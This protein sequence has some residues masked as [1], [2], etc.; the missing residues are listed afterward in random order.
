MKNRIFSQL[1]HGAIVSMA[2]VV[3]IACERDPANAGLPYVDGDQIS[4]GAME[5]VPVVMYT[6]PFDSV[7]SNDPSSGIGLFGGYTD[8]VFGRHD[9]Q[10][11]AH[12]LPD[13]VPSFGSNPVCDSAYLYIPFT[14]TSSAWYGDTTV[15]MNIQVYSLTHF[16]DPDSSYYSHRQFAT[17]QLIGDTTMAPNPRRPQSFEVLSSNR[18]VLKI[19]ID[20][21]F[22]NNTI[23]PLEGTGA[24]ES[25]DNFINQFYGIQLKSD[26]SAES[27]LG[28]LMQSTVTRLRIHFSNDTSTVSKLNYDLRI[29]SSAMFVNT[30]QHDYSMAD[31]DLNNQN[32]VDGEVRGY[33]QT[34]AGV[35]TAIE[36]PDLRHYRDSAWLL[37]RAELTLPVAEGSALNYRL[38]ESLQLVIDD[39]TSRRFIYDYSS[40]TDQV[41]GDLAI[42]ELRDHK[43]EFLLTRQMQRFLDGRDSIARFILVPEFN[44]SDQARVILNG[45]NSTL[46]PLE[47]KMYFTRTK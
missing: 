20:P 19:P 14:L 22:V 44:S 1:I 12:L 32:T 18:P 17:D 13:G 46:E 21:Q 7:R 33:A 6:T 36:I 45:Y 31:F 4:F 38:P 39:S 43:Y 42:G 25:G 2:F 10:V 16:L 24:F 35:V 26:A 40:T 27:I 15:P 29:G 8:P 47:F 5:S 23:F 28:L 41:G 37:N 11:T 3:F 30:F 34:M 9:A